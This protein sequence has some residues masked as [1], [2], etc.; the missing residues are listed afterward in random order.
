[1]VKV[2]KAWRS[3]FAKDF[4]D[5]RLSYSS[6]WLMLFKLKA[7]IKPKLKPCQGLSSAKVQLK[8]KLDPNKN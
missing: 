1:M 4:F 8:P 3:K 2:L 5:L 6:P 7:Y